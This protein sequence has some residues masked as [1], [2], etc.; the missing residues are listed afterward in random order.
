MVV[1]PEHTVVIDDKWS[2]FAQ[3][4]TVDNPYRKRGLETKKIDDGYPRIYPKGW[5]LRKLSFT[6]KPSGDIL[7]VRDELEGLIANKIVKFSSIFIGVFNAWINYSIN[8][9]DGTPNH[10]IVT[11]EVQEVYTGEEL[12]TE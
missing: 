9:E 7:V 12:V 4:I 6:A 8:Y 11:F 3:E 5:E 2:C 10:T 1:Y